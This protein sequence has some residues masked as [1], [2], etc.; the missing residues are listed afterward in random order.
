VL[1][2]YPKNSTYTQVYTV[3]AFFMFI[4]FFALYIVFLY[5]CLTLMVAVA[6]LIAAYTPVLTIFIFAIAK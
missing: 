2:P 1:T 6:L 3:C 5:L 4:I